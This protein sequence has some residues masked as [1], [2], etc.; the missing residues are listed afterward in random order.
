MT[1]CDG[2][3]KPKWDL[4]SQKRTHLIASARGFSYAEEYEKEIVKRMQKK[5]SESVCKHAN[6]VP[7]REF[8]A[9][10]AIRGTWSSDAARL[11]AYLMPRRLTEL[12]FS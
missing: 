11:H 6:N 7:I 10:I 9:M 5:L 3:R 2:Y 4:R 8:V 1:S 12:H